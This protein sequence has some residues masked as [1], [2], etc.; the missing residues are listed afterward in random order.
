MRQV[1]V[2]QGQTIVDIALQEYGSVEGLFAFLEANQTLDL[3]SELEP[4]QKVL[5]REEDVVN[6]D[7]VNYYQRNNISVI[8]SL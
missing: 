3:D 5:V 6:S 2:Q 1:I 4:G 8:S 7:I